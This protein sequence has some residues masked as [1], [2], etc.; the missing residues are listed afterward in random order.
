MPPTK[1]KTA[2]QLTR[3]I[4]AALAKP[5]RRDVA[6]R[7]SGTRQQQATAE[8]ADYG[9]W[10]RAT[11]DQIE[12]WAHANNQEWDDRY[13][14]WMIKRLDKLVLF[15]RSFFDHDPQELIGHEDAAALIVLPKAS[16]LKLARRLFRT[17]KGIAKDLQADD[18]WFNMDWFV[19]A[20]EG[21]R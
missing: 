16:A 4:N 1:K 2:A 6:E 15:L 18:L 17:G 9:Q 3:E 13:R 5:S 7:R 12:T 19:P 11:L 10:R 21:Y 8:A 20:G 14:D